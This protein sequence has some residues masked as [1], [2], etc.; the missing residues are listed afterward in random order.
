MTQVT[1]TNLVG[2]LAPALKQALETSAGSAMNQGVGAIEVEHWIL[3][4]I[5]QKDPMLMTLCESQKAFNRCL[6][7]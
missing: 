7:Q 5:S 6:S 4:L 1:L 2:K 3:Q